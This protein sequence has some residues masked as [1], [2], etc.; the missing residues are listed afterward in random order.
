MESRDDIVAIVKAEIDKM[1]A[2]FIRKFWYVMFG[3]GI[4][5]A[6]AWYS[7]YY[8]VQQLDAQRDTDIAY[9]KDQIAENQ[10]QIDTL[11]SDY[12]SD[13]KEIKED[14]K[15]IRNQY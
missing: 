10:K 9:T 11:R 5:S 6:A 8:Q 14:V 15:Y 7:L 3:M 2:D 12:K 4:T 13:I 1:I